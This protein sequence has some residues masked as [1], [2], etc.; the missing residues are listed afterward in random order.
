MK[1]DRLFTWLEASVTGFFLSFTAMAC[2]STA[3]SMKPVS[4]W[5]LA[6]CCAAGGVLC[7]FLCT[8]RLGL[9]ML[10]LVALLLGFM[11][12][13]GI[14]LE[15]LESLLNKISRVY[16]DAYNWQIIRWSWRDVLDMEKT[17]APIIY[18]CGGLIAAIAA[19][20][21]AK[22]QSSIVAGLPAVPPVADSVAT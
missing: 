2:L 12:Q 14:L 1:R 10:G 3:F 15:S 18:L 7:A 17:L 21:V 20:T 13:N 9:V 16:H 11:W 4:L 19:W 6:L 22:G 5:L 8:R